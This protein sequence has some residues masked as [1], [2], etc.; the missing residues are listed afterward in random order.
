MENSSNGRSTSKASLLVF[1]LFGFV[2][3]VAFAG[4]AFVTVAANTGA[5]K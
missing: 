3:P 2:L 5:L 1:V 4:W